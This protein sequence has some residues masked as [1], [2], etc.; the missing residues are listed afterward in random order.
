MPKNIPWWVPQ[1]AGTE[2]DNIRAVL[3]SNYLNDGEVTRR[4]ERQ[5]AEMAG[6][7]HAVAATSGTAAIFMGLAAC[8]V[9][10]GDEV[11]VPDMTFIATANAVRLAGATPVLVDVDR[12]TLTMD[13][14]AAERAIT[15][16]TKAIVPVHV[17]GRAGTLPQIL[18][19]AKARKLAVV[20][21]AAEAFLSRHNGQ[22]LGTLGNAGCF[23]FSPAKTIST[24]QGG[25]VVTSDAELHTRLRQLKDQGR[26]VTGTGGDDI[27]PVVGY[28]FKMTNLQAAIGLAQLPKANE[29][30]A[31]MREIQRLYKSELSSLRGL[32]VLP[33]GPHEVPQ[34][35]DV[36]I[37][38][39]DH[40]ANELRENGMQSRNFWFPVH[41]Q[42]PYRLSDDAFPNSTWASPRAL[43][44]PSAYTLTD[45]DVHSVCEVIR[46]VLN[47]TRV[48]SGHASGRELS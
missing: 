46:R 40:V 7:P 37:D 20:E 2:L 42:A 31:R 34:W 3:D 1:L 11:L 10:P 30:I 23:S 15:K 47:R 33:F 24:G 8:G 26:A 5:F 17:T 12:A 27:H 43:W 44:L 41:T 35:T 21:D 16:R 22:C 48:L 19:L 28:N 13:P 25:M 18:A 39:R 4:F 36:L 9:G 29:R 38:D 6:V 45:G 14:A 32:T